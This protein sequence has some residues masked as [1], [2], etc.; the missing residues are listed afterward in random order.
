MDLIE[1]YIEKECIDLTEDQKAT[2]L[3]TYQTLIIN[4]IDNLTN[5]QICSIFIARK[6][7]RRE[8]TRLRTLAE[9]N[10]KVYFLNSR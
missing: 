4:D 8:T 5:D 10:S 6:E 2:A 1:Q 9:C 3:E 7:K